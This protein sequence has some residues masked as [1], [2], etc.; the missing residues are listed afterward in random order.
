MKEVGSKQ[1]SEGR[2]RGRKGMRESVKK[3]KEGGSDRRREGGESR[4]QI[5][6]TSPTYNSLQLHTPLT[7]TV[8]ATQTT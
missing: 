4:V 2:E 8:E 5:N 3:A 7:L 6:Y 1:R